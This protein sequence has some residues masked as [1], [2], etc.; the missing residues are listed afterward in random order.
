MGNSLHPVLSAGRALRRS[1]M[2]EILTNIK[3]PELVTKRR[4]QIMRTAMELFRKN[5]YH[6][7]TMREICAKS[8]VNMGSFYDYFGGKEDILVFIYKEMMY[9]TGSFDG[10]IDRDV[11]GWDD[12]EPFLRII[13]LESWNKNKKSI[14]LMYRE[15]IAL[16]KNTLR[17]VM[18][19]E[20][21]FVKW[22]AEKLRRG[23][24]CPKVTRELEII[25]NSVAY[26][27]SFIPLR[28]W[29]MHHIDQKKIL[30]SLVGMFMARLGQLRKP[31]AGSEI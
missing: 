31:P 7:T 19:I 12:L 23:V 3:K 6:A 1:T 27:N 21:D 13:L 5:G 10:L 22:I 4:H 28:G 16:D 2:R 9:E 17:A 15:T 30:D 20:S 14:Q 18:G 26:F 24:G 11:L 25:A 29:N 8:R